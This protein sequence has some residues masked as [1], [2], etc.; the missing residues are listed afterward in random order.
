MFSS[1]VKTVKGGV[2]SLA[3]R[4]NGGQVSEGKDSQPAH[5]DEKK[6]GSK[7][8]LDFQAM[9]MTKTDEQV[10]VRFEVLLARDFDFNP[11]KDRVVIRGLDVTKTDRWSSEGV[12]MRVGSKAPKSGPMEG[13][14]RLVGFTTLPKTVSGLIIPYKYQLVQRSPDKNLWENLKPD[15]YVYNHAW[16]RVL[17]IPT[18]FNGE[19]FNQLD[20]AILGEGSQRSRLEYRKKATGSFLPNIKRIVQDQDFLSLKENITRTELVFETH[21]TGIQ[22]QRVYPYSTLQPALKGYDKTCKDVGERLVEKI[23]AELEELILQIEVRLG[24]E[25]L[26]EHV[27]VEAGVFLALYYVLCQGKIHRFLPEITSKQLGLLATALRPMIQEGK[28][29]K[30]R[31][32]E[33]IL[34]NENKR[35]GVA[36][37]FEDGLN[38]IMKTRAFKDNSEQLVSV[39]PIVHFL[40]EATT[41]ISYFD[42]HKANSKI[43]FWGIFSL[44]TDAL[45]GKTRSQQKSSILSPPVFEDMKAWSAVYPQLPV[46]YLKSLSPED[47]LTVLADPKMVDFWSLNTLIVVGGRLIQENVSSKLELSKALHTVI[48]PQL[49][50]L[51]EVAA[52]LSIPEAKDLEFIMKTMTVAMLDMYKSDEEFVFLRRILEICAAVFRVMFKL[53]ETRNPT[54]PP[55][56]SKIM[57]DLTLE[58][59]EGAIQGRATLR[60]QSLFI[61]LSDLINIFHGVGVTDEF[62]ARSL[63]KCREG[64]ERNTDETILE[65]YTEMNLQDV[66]PVMKRM[67]EE[68][69]LQLMDAPTSHSFIHKMFSIP[70]K[71]AGLFSGGSK[72]NDMVGLVERALQSSAKHLNLGDSFEVADF[73]L[74]DTSLDKII[75]YDLSRDLSPSGQQLVNSLLDS[76]RATAESLVQGR[77]HVAML[78]PFLN[79]SNECL[80]SRIPASTNFKKIL[81]LRKEEL[82]NYMETTAEVTR[83][84]QMLNQQQNIDL[85]EAIRSMKTEDE[86]QSSAID[87]LWVPRMKEEEEIDV[88]VPS[89]NRRAQEQTR[90]FMKYMSSEV[91][92]NIYRETLT[93]GE[94]LSADSDDEEGDA[95]N[96]T[97][98]KVKMIMRKIV[99]PAISRFEQIGQEL[100][101]KE[102]KLT[103]VD[104][105]FNEYREDPLELKKEL[106][107]IARTQGKHLADDTHTKIWTRLQMAELRSTAKMILGV[108]YSLGIQTEFLEIKKIADAGTRDGDVSANLASVSV[109][110]VKYGEVFKGW[111]TKD[112]QSIEEIEKSQALIKWIRDHV[113]SYQV[114]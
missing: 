100:E 26:L 7:I 84:L 28:C 72:K 47:F 32:F 46:S 56:L 33:H 25:G 104:F 19:F 114:R 74:G 57:V 88:M 12:E 30:L 107:A 103:E 87:S 21:T 10:V 78:K 5:E 23:F 1:V 18:E 31:A 35:L 27:K 53:A 106:N 98:E 64:L 79:V 52:T 39:F 4:F 40:R 50:E 51:L 36:R 22:L 80:Q 60:L 83:F 99:C 75:Q 71:I 93:H 17:A 86:L 13:I 82:D 11:L 3:S 16:N 97:K 111:G 63:V 45:Y 113:N 29:L 70:R 67:V 9:C 59:V 109:E 68:K 14:T 89:I 112:I 90:I 55:A 101:D 96:E 24:E 66:N 20:D 92:R 102:I 77:A 61:R 85:T 108:K 43:K 15:G 73:V 69:A 48:C 49:G 54:E 76:F 94:D 95:I 91:F 2:K 41:K 38:K 81:L 37:I 58:K 65:V 44:S 8:E 34:N 6:L 42:A 105:Y 62:L 110:D